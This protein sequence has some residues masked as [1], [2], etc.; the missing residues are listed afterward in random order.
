VVRCADGGRRLEHF[1]IR[2]TSDS[3][4]TID[5][6]SSDPDDN[7]VLECAVSAGSEMVVTGD[8]DLLRLAS[9]RGIEIVTV[10]DFLARFSGPGS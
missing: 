4:R 6:V 7:R 8:A 1:G 2:E 9:F 5:T 10:A 3:H